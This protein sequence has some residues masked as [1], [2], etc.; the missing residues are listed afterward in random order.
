MD[1]FCIGILHKNVRKVFKVTPL[2]SSS[3]TDGTAGLTPQKGMHPVEV[4]ALLFFNRLMPLTAEYLRNTRR[5][6]GLYSVQSVGAAQ[7]VSLVIGHNPG[8]V[9]T[10]TQYTSTEVLRRSELL[11][12]F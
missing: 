12:A 1:I 2:Y 7:A 3:T 6:L 5:R 4:G 8:R 9:A 11:R 10:P